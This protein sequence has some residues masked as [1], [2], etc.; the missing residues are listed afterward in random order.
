M[1]DFTIA[2]VGTGVIGTSMGLALKRIEDSPRLVA[3]DKDVTIASKA[4]KMGAFDKVEWNLVNACESADL[5]VLSIPLSGVKSTLEAIGPYLKQNAVVTDTCASKQAVLTWA[6]EMLPAHVHFVGGD[7]IVHAAGLGFENARANLF[8]GRLYCLTPAPQAHEEAVQLLTSLISLLGAEPFFLD[9]VEH[10]GLLTAVEHLPTALSLALMRVLSKQ[11]TWR[12]TR[13]LAG[14]RFEQVSAAAAGD[15]DSLKDTFLENKQLLVHWLDRYV[16]ELQ[17]LRALLTD[18]DDVDEPLAQH[19]DE[20][21]VARLN[22]LKD[23]QAGGFVEP[24]LAS[25][26]I[27][28]PG[29]FERLIGFGAFRKRQGDDK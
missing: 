20:A 6:T 13:K 28:I 9:P 1:S 22:W 2:V 16:E 21:V 27:E 12:E 24:E 18:P 26:K 25:Q 8:D 14:G 17:K 7:P 11:G 10:D 23:Y 4:A 5:V 29:F 19:I 3:H 15:P